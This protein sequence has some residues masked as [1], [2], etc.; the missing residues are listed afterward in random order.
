MLLVQHLLDTAAVAERMWDQWLPAG[1]RHRLCNVAPQGDGRRWFAWVC[2]LHDI[3]KATPAFQ[4]Q[5]D[6]LRQR[7]VKAGF[8]S[9]KQR[10]PADR[11]WRHEKAS[12]RTLV[13]A[14]ASR[15]WAPEST[16]WV[17]PLLAGHHG[18]VCNESALDLRRRPPRPHG[19]EPVWDEARETILETV[20]RAVGYVSMGQAEPVTVPVRADQLA[21]SGLLI[22]ADWIAS[23][24]DMFVG[25]DDLGDVSM[26]GARDRAELAWARLGLVRGFTPGFSTAD[27]PVQARF[28][29]E[30]RGLQTL[31]CEVARCVADVPLLV[32]E[33]PT[34]EGKSEAA[35]AAAEILAS[36]FGADG[37]FVGLPTQATSDAMFV[38]VAGWA[39]TFD[40]PLPVSLLH[41]KRAL[42]ETWKSLAR[43]GTVVYP[44]ESA[45]D[46]YGLPD[47]LPSALSDWQVDE[48]S[49]RDGAVAAA[50]WFD[51]A[52]RGLLAPVVV[53]TVDQLLFAAT[54][55]KHVALRFAG[56]AGK[57]VVV[58]E[59]HA[60]DVYMRQF[61]L[62]ALRWLGQAR[63]PVLLLSATLPADQRRALVSAYLSGRSG[64]PEVSC[65]LSGEGGYPQVVVAVAPEGVPAVTV[66]TARP[67]RQPAPMSLQILEERV[68]DPDIDLVDSVRDDLR[69][70]GCV[71]IVRNTVNRAQATFQAFVAAFG[72]DEVRLLHSR[73]T[74]GHRAEDTAA[75]LAALGPRGSRPKRLVVVATQVAEQSFDIDADLVVSDLAPADLLLQRAGR[76]HRHDRDASQR[77]DRLRQPRLVVTG[78]RFEQH[79]IWL[80]S[81]STFVYDRAL[82]LRTAQLL[83]E[84]AERG[85]LQLPGD[86]PVFVSE[87][88]DGYCDDLARVADAAKYVLAGAAGVTARTLDGLHDLDAGDVADEDSAG[89]VLVRDGDMGVE[90]LLVN[91]TEDGYRTV[92]GTRVGRNGEAVEQ[93]TQ[94]AADLVRLPARLSKRA[95]DELGPLPAWDDH[96]WLR[97][98]RVL[99]ATSDD[100]RALQGVEVG[101]DRTLGLTI[102]QGP[103]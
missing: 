42:N 3:G 49:C 90:V 97:H 26:A 1:L 10:R 66:R 16:S 59:V 23:N 99:C 71:L 9:W 78:L 72:D 67:W 81:A 11:L 30:P 87:V 38:R 74:A 70:G 65:R 82:L 21:W 41:A 8:G 85:T 19:R 94:I 51:G 4:L 69:E 61:L 13:D 28:G 22:A 79:G 6:C 36:R 91:A 2:G 37:V 56:L 53:G 77:P 47:E 62:E 12:A 57:V 76:L 44:A 45:L 84:R 86:V 31:I 98:V 29:C 63:V 100:S 34:G 15:G 68:D 39:A 17:W 35:L 46:P 83:V 93:P 25:V 5:H 48:P 40:P 96:P 95:A 54:R 20:T 52:K 103:L 32:V 18:Y 43:S 55:T 7:Y 75:A 73:F 50:E 60:A 101:Y 80:P 88:Y 102:G 24:C 64:V 89:R 58:D 92:S 14:A 27:D 33:A